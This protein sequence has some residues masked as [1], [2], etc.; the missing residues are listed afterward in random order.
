MPYGLI[1]DGYTLK[2]I[3]KQEEEA[4]KDLKKHENF[5]TFLGSPQSGTAV[6]GLAIGVVL[7]LFIIP[8]IKNFLK[9]LATDE[10]YKGKTVSQ[11]VAEEEADPTGTGFLRLLTASSIGIPETL[12][13]VIIPAPLQEEIR[14]ATGVD[15]GG[16]FSTLRGKI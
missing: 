6:A 16:L 9:L 12:I 5:K 2:K 13:G 14:K 3:T 4:L 10:Q 1:P 15:I 11:I 7:L 8:I